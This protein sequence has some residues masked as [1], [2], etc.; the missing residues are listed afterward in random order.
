M[1]CKRC[2]DVSCLYVDM[3]AEKPRGLEQRRP[4]G[5]SVGHPSVS[6]NNYLRDGERRRHDVTRSSVASSL[7]ARTRSQSV[8]Q[9]AARKSQYQ[10]SPARRPARPSYERPYRRSFVASC[11]RRHARSIA[12]TLRDRTPSPAHPPRPSLLPVNICDVGP[13]DRACRQYI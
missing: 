7:N 2:V 4:V 6:S 10:T 1:Y 13:S 9:R 11:C 5:L 8:N 3:T 12:A